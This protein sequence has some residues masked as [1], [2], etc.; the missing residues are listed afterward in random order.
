MEDISHVNMWITF[1]HVNISLIGMLIPSN[2]K[3]INFHDTVM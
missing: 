2:S 1:S 3:L